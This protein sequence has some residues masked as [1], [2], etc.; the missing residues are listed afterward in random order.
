[1]VP[2]GWEQ[3]PVGKLCKSI[4]PGRN[5]PELNDGTIPWVTTPE[6]TGRFIPSASQKHFTSSSA[7]KA[8]AGKTVPPNSVVMTCVG[9]LGIV[10]I[11]SETVALNQQLHAFVCG[12]SVIHGYLAYWLTTQVPYMNSLSSQTTIPYLNKA[13]CERIPVLLPP[14][15]EQKKI[16]EILSTWDRAIE[17]AERELENARLQKKALMQQLLTGTRRLP[18]FDGEWKTVKLGD[19]ARII[20]SN[21]DK[22]TKE[23]EPK[24]RLCNYM[25]VYTNDDIHASS[26]FMEATASAQQIKKYTVRADDVIITKDSEDPK[27]IAIPAYVVSDA[28]DLVCGYHL[29]ILRPLNQIEGRF[30]KY[31]I[32]T[33]RLK[34]FFGSRAN[35]AIRFGLTLPSIQEA[36][37]LIPSKREQKAISGALKNCE[38]QM[39]ELQKKISLLRTEKRALMQQLLTGK[40]RVTV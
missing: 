26:A 10:A 32:E 27:D 12:P 5:K 23:G 40:K 18:G 17:V 37:F 35:G 24:V 16:A 1:M 34:H 6:I 33:P 3:V 20:V 11:A 38:E 22:K 9:E 28:D 25:D 4:V 30:L 21:V 15:S 8:A 39:R 36:E 7:L 14:L 19:V 13:N 29:A 31:L 2:E